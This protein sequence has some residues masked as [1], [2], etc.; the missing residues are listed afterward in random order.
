MSGE[1]PR[2]VAYPEDRRCF[3]SV[4]AGC[5]SMIL[6]MSNLV[7]WLAIE[8]GWKVFTTEGKEFGEVDEVVG[9]D[10]TDIFDGLSIATDALGQPRYVT[11]EQVASIEQGVVR[12]ALDREHAEQLGGYEQPATS[13][14]IE[15]DDRDSAFD[16]VAADMRDVKGDIVEPTQGHEHPFNFWT[17]LAHFFRRLRS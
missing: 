2:F 8:P 6:P 7:S 13:V 15:P 9:D 1:Y 14:E 12:L 5:P 17:R 10:T 3:E 16:H 11:A 4:P